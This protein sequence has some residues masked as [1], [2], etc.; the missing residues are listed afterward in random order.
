M[1]RLWLTSAP[2]TSLAKADVTTELETWADGY[3]TIGP[4]VRHPVKL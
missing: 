2:G 1:K 4:T 3:D